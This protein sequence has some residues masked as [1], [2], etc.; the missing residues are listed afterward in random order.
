MFI[1]L[2]DVV[3]TKPLRTNHIFKLQVIEHLNK[4]SKVCVSQ[5]RIFCKLADLPAGWEKW[6]SVQLYN[7]H[8]H[9]SHYRAYKYI[10]EESEADGAP[11]KLSGFSVTRLDDLLRQVGESGSV[12]AVT[13]RTGA[14]DEL[15]EECDRLLTWILALIL[16]HAS[17]QDHTRT[18]GHTTDSSPYCSLY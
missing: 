2:F 11:L 9:C 7:K 17:L 5:W 6:V 1:F 13:L 3:V 16:H 15:V 8:C 14:G 12:E 10:L 18:Q 4:W